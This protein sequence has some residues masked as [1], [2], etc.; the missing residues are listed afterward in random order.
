MSKKCRKS[1]IKIFQTFRFVVECPIYIILYRYFL[2][3]LP[4]PRTPGW[5]MASWMM[6]L[7]T[8]RFWFAPS[9]SS[10]PSPLRPF[11]TRFLHRSRGLPNSLFPHGFPFDNSCRILWSSD[12]ITYPIHCN[13]YVLMRWTISVII[14]I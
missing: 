10:F 4:S 1:K 9:R 14:P 12:H 11:E 3:E 2:K 7:Q 13:L 6:F 8:F 5:V